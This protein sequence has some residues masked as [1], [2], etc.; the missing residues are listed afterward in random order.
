MRRWG[1]WLLGAALALS[2]AACNEKSEAESKRCAADIDCIQAVCVAGTCDEV[3]CETATECPSGTCDGLRCVA[4]ECDL[5]RDC[6][7]P[8]GC[9]G[10]LCRA[11][12]DGMFR[13]PPRRDAGAPD[14]SLRRDRGLAD[15]CLDPEPGT[16]ARCD[17]EPDAAA[18]ED[19][20]VPDQGPLDAGPDRGPDA[21][22][23]PVLA[24]TYR[25]EFERDTS[26]CPDL[27]G[28][29]FDG[30][31]NRLVIDPDDRTRPGQLDGRFISGDLT[32]ALVGTRVGNGFR[33]TPVAPVDL[34][35]AG[36]SI[37][38]TPAFEGLPAP[39]VAG[40]VSGRMRTFMEEVGDCPNL[41]LG[42]TR[43]D[44]YYGFPQ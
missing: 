21:G 33:L 25:L 15:P 35:A 7:A 44:A 16:T 29:S 6:E 28:V 4:R 39:D 26:E 23:P 8:F 13:P 17:A 36:C 24:G 18:V 11:P 9:N 30:D 5:D 14:A 2:P 1:G 41:V 10:G 19:A 20:A 40:A 43:V 3:P 37:R 32:V 38:L 42:C 27:D 31:G 22:A 12:S 34:P